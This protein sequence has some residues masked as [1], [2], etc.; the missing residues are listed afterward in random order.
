MQ[1]FKDIQCVV[2]DTNTGKHVQERAVTLAGIN[3]ASLA[4][5]DSS[6]AYPPEEFASRRAHL[7]QI[8]VMAGSL[9]LSGIHNRL[10]NATHAG[11]W[12]TK[13]W[14]PS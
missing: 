9:A 13:S 11:R 1:R 6:D 14:V 4:T 12:S 10:Q 7:W 5:V 3:Q 8:P 2:E